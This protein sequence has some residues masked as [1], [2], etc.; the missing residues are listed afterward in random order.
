M[1]MAFR[2]LKEETVNQ[3]KAHETAASDLKK[4][5]ANPFEE[6]AVGYKVC[7]P[8][9]H[10]GTRLNVCLSKDRLDESRTDLVEGYLSAYEY[11]QGEVWYMD[12]P[13]FFLLISYFRS[14]S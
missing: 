14:G 3:G 6:W 11:A 2:G 5:I 12:T 13:L 8:D 7:C 9:S 4:K 10:S 1:Q